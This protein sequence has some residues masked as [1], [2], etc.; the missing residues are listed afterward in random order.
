MLLSPVLALRGCRFCFIRDCRRRNRKHA[1]RAF[2]IFRTFPLL[3][4][5]PSFLHHLTAK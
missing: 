3:P 4:Y 2:R 1:F 5:R